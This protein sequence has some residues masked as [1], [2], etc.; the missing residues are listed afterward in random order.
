MINY[1]FNANHF[2]PCSICGIYIKISKT[3]TKQEYLWYLYL[4]ASGEEQ[5]EICE[6]CKNKKETK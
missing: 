6:I 4:E 5:K 1:I 3:K 2:V